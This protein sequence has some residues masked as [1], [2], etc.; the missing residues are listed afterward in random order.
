MMQFDKYPAFFFINVTI[1]ECNFTMGTILGKCTHH[2]TCAFGTC[3]CT[4]PIPEIVPMVKLDRHR[5]R[6]TYLLW[7]KEV[8]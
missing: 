3:A 8:S 7:L 4:K 6:K 5:H 2:S 1:R